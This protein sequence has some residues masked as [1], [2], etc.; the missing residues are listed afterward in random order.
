[1][2]LSKDYIGCLQS[3]FKSGEELRM[4]LLNTDIYKQGM[5]RKLQRC[6]IMIFIG[7]KPISTIV[8]IRP[9]SHAT[10][11][12]LGA[13]PM[14]MSFQQ[15]VMLEHTLTCSEQNWWTF[16]RV[17]VQLLSKLFLGWALLHRK[18]EGGCIFG[19]NARPWTLTIYRDT[20]LGLYCNTQS[21]VLSCLTKHVCNTRTRF[22][23][24]L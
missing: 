12:M 15:A 24:L 13:C 10:C 23:K 3:T 19:N 8:I 5:A 14:F 2:Q 20:V 16:I 21:C 17:W 6:N 7:L 22:V 11:N 9:F 18:Q 1:M 4:M